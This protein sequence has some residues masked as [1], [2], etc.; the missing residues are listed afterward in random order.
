MVGWMDVKTDTH[1]HKHTHTHT[2]RHT[3]TC[4][5]FIEQSL[6][7]LSLGGQHRG[8]ELAASWKLSLLPEHQGARAE[9]ASTH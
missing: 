4:T 3:F 8:E 1:T 9:A 6:I 7:K 2:S 5:H